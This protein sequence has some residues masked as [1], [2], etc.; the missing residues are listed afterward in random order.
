MDFLV[1]AIA[2]VVGLAILAPGALRFLKRNN[3]STS[4]SS[5]GG[6]AGCGNAGGKPDGKVQ[7][8]QLKRK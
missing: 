4:Q 7:L 8:I 3:S 2:V 1:P 6:C 5:C